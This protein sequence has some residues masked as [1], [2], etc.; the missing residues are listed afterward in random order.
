VTR[1]QRCG[2]AA[3][4][5]FWGMMAPAIS[6]AGDLDDLKS[7]Q[8]KYAAAFEPKDVDTIVALTSRDFLDFPLD[9]EAPVDWSAKGDQ[10]R[11][12]ALS[13]LLNRYESWTVK[14]LDAE[15]K[16]TGSTGVV[17]GWEKVARKPKDG[18]LEYLRW[19]FTAT[20]TKS[21]GKW[22]MVAAHR[23]TTPA[24]IPGAPATAQ[25][26]AEERI[27]RTALDGP[28]FANVPM[29]DARL[30]RVLAESASAKQVVELG[31]STGFS[32]LWFCD[33]IRKNGGHLTT[34]EINPQRAKAAREA[35]ARA[36]VENLVTLVEGDAHQG[37]RKLT[38]PIDVVFIDAE[39]DGYPDYLAQLLPLVRPGGLILAHNMRW[40]APSPAYVKA[41]TTDPG[42]E[43]VFVNMDDQGIGITLKKR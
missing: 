19:R 12:A 9:G 25:D 16:V 3:C 36:G 14:L 11:R 24:T 22:L 21:D 40:P 33:A 32:A 20:W 7:A 27:L 15:Y 28:R 17:S 41:V 23:S 34:F 6:F 5:V 8:E 38:G 30:L 39:K 42:L 43:T 2:L 18:V 13:D 29:V 10:Q 31:T 1:N 4:T 37:I 26:S 35:F